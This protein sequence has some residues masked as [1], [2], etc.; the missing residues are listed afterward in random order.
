MCW[1]CSWE[2]GIDIDSLTPAAQ[3]K[4]LYFASQA[5]ILIELPE[6][7]GVFLLDQR[8]SMPGAKRTFVIPIPDQS[9]DYRYEVRV[10][11]VSN[12]KKYFKRI[13]IDSFRAGMILAVKVDAPPVPEGELPQIIVATAVLA[14]GGKPPEDSEEEEIVVQ[15]S[16][17]SR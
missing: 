17:V 4:K 16:L 2:E 5:R 8:M 3:S 12:G 11:V 10:D 7:S 9:V 1:D 6:A 14:E 13:K 15:R